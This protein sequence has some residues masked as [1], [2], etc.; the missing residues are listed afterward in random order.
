VTK[1]NH[2]KSPERSC[3]TTTTTKSRRRRR[4]RRIVQLNPLCNFVPGYPLSVLVIGIT[5][6]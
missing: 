3:K 4:R 2:K 1:D 6:M 5:M